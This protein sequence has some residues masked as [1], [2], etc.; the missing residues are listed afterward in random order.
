MPSPYAPAASR[1]IRRG[2][3][4]LAGAVALLLVATGVV[5]VN[6]LT[7][8]DGAASPDAAVRKLFDALEGEDMIGVLESLPPGERAAI[9]EPAEQLV[10]ELQRL[11]IL[12]DYDLHDLPGIDIEIDGLELDVDELGDGVSAVRITGGEITATANASEL[13]VGD[14]V[15]DLADDDLDLPD[16]EETESGDLAD[17]DL[18][19]VTIREGGGWHVSLF[20]SIAEAARGDAPV[21]DFG[22]GITP[23]GADSPEG[24]VRGLLDAATDLDAEGVIAMLPPD[25]MRVLYDYGPLFLDEAEEARDEAFDDGLEL[26]VD[27]LVLRTEGGGSRRTV[28]IEGF[29]MSATADGDSVHMAW[30]GTCWTMEGVGF[31]DNREQFSFEGEAVAAA[32]PED[33]NEDFDEFAGF[34]EHDEEDVQSDD[35]TDVLEACTDGTVTMNGDAEEFDETGLPDV[36]GILDAGTQVAGLRVVEVDG[37]WYVSPLRSMFD[38]MLAMLGEVERDDIEDLVSS[39]EDW[40]DEEMDQPYE[41]YDD[42]FDYDD[43][44]DDDADDPF[45]DDESGEDGYD[46]ELWKSSP[47]GAPRRLGGV[48]VA[49]TATGAVGLDAA[50]GEELWSTSDCD[51]ATWGDER[52]TEPTTVA[53]LRCANALYAL[54]PA[55]GQE[56]WRRDD[57]SSAFPNIGAEVTVFD[58]G[59]AVSVV[60]NATGAELWTSPVSIATAATGGGAVYL[61]TANGEVVAYDARTGAERWRSPLQSWNVVADATRVVVTDGSD[62]LHLLDPATGAERATVAAPT[63][64]YQSDLLTTPTLLL[65]TVVTEDETVVTAYDDTGAVRWTRQLDESEVVVASTPA[66][67]VGVSSRSSVNGVCDLALLDEATGEPTHELDDPSCGYALIETAAVITYALTENWDALELVTTPIE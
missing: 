62:V 5:A 36:R 24:A 9:G 50:T 23:V 33:Y 12:A 49:P 3:A 52:L 46:P 30:D 39:V 27:D 2:R 67:R 48:L 54:D 19:L 14:L 1:P 43:E 28:V 26:T 10:R 53:V 34:A 60:D 20:Y 29:E 55:T 64:G 22:N 11:E 58:T 45:D 63:D 25:E 40:W 41:D 18:T 65:Q 21:P 47:T 35:E 42:P 56:L 38:P 44:Y 17:A 15:R 59:E 61:A 7:G 37:R 4:A 6:A 66:G 31:D 57:D 13:P 32:D 51:F 16:D 8:G